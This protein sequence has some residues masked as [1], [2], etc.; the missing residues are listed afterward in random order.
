M[1]TVV[2]NLFTLSITLITKKN[3][4]RLQHAKNSRTECY[5]LYGQIYIRLRRKCW[6]S[7]PISIRF[8]SIRI[9]TFRFVAGLIA[10]I[11]VRSVRR[12]L[13]FVKRARSH[14][15]SMQADPYRPLERNPHP[16]KTP[17]LN[18]RE[19]NV[20]QI[21]WNSHGICAVCGGFSWLMH[22]S[23]WFFFALCPLTHDHCILL[24]LNDL[25]RWIWVSFDPVMASAD[26]H[27]SWGMRMGERK[28]LKIWDAWLAEEFGASVGTFVKLLKEF[29]LVRY[30]LLI[31]GESKIIDNIFHKC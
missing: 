1:N 22:S 13:A 11:I 15:R 18:S 6:R 14:S 31:V 7:Y 9:D 10:T 20:P 17:V 24:P 4:K 27:F 23:R 12:P 16:C 2:F 26:I 19:A 21:L 28:L 30:F 3:N 8:D 29:K 5:K 25:N